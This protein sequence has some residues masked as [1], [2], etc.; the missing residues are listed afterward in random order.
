MAQQAAQKL[1]KLC[2]MVADLKQGEDFSITRLTVIKSL[3]PDMKTAARFAAH[4]AALA[5]RRKDFDSRGIRFKP[6]EK[7]RH[8]Q[9]AA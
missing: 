4:L 3:C 6:A 1:R 8:Q 9:L 7:K 2:Q 5:Q